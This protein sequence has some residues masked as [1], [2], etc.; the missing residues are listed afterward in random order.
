M[1]SFFSQEVSNMISCP[2]CTQ[3]LLFAL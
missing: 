2:Q 1:F 3:E